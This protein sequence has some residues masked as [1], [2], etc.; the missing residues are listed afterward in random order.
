MTS[1]FT[2]LHVED[3]AGDREIVAAA[4]RKVAPQ[5]RI[6]SVSDG[7]E[8]VGY[9]S[10]LGPF[11]DRARSPLPGLLLLDLKLPRKSGLEVLEWVRA[12]ADLKNLP[13]FM[14]T[15]SGDPADLERARALGVNSY[16]TKPVSLAATREIVAGIAE[17]VSLS[18][19]SGVRPPRAEQP[20]L[21]HG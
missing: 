21:I 20:G 3:D 13:V 11:Q 4:F 16:F 8:A 18:E 7:V 17:Y 2:V 15:S 10:G 9:L 14:L 19:L 6:E 1:V 5:L 12:H